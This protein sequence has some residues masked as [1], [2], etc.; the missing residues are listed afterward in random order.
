MNYKELL[1]K[2]NLLL[3]ENNRLTEENN[4]LKAQLGI[5]NFERLKINVARNI[6]YLMKHAIFWQ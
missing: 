1:E 2:Y 3:N 6:F 5:T 4:R